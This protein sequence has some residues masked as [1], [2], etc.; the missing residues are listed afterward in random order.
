MELQLGNAYKVAGQS[1]HK[2]PTWNFDYTTIKTICSCNLT[3]K[4]RSWR[5]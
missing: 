4:S 5:L 3:S 2:A 1:K